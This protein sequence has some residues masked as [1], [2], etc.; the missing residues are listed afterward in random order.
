MF[1]II[2]PVCSAPVIG[3]LTWS[4]LKAKRLGVI[5]SLNP[6]ATLVARTR[7]VESSLATRVRSWAVEVDLIGLILLGAGWTCVCASDSL[8]KCVT[9]GLG[10]QLLL[11]LTLANAGS[12]PFTNY[13]IVIMLTFGPTLLLLFV[14][15]EARFARS[16]CLP[17]RFFVNRNGE[18]TAVAI[19]P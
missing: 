5:H 1:A 15:W 8:S 11:P 3:A 18:A 16:P 13:K 4:Q 2:I 19:P 14:C 6:N 10:H 9:D 17:A 7:M 12:L